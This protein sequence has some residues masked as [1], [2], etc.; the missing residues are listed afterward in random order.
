MS[1]SDEQVRAALFVVQ[2][3]LAKLNAVQPLPADFLGD[4]LADLDAIGA[5]ISVTNLLATIRIARKV[6]ELLRAVRLPSLKT[7]GDVAAPLPPAMRRQPSPA[8]GAGAARPAAVEGKTLLQCAEDLLAKLLFLLVAKGAAVDQ[9]VIDQGFLPLLLNCLLEEGTPSGK[10]FAA[11]ALLCCLERDGLRDFV[12][13]LPGLSGIVRFLGDDGDDGM[14]PLFVDVVALLRSLAD[15]PEFPERFAIDEV[16]VGLV[17]AVRVVPTYE[18]VV[19]NVFSFLQLFSGQKGFMHRLFSEFGEPLIIVLA[20]QVLGMSR[21]SSDALICV[22]D[23]LSSVLERFEWLASLGSKIVEPVDISLCVEFLSVN[24]DPQVLKSVLHLIA[25]FCGDLNCVARFCCFREFVSLFSKPVVIDNPPVCAQLLNVIERFTFYNQNYCPNKLV[26]A[27]PRLLKS[28]DVLLLGSTLRI[29]RQ[30]TA[31]G[32][33]FLMSDLVPQLVVAQVANDDPTVSWL[34]LRTVQ[35]FL[36]LFG[37]VAAAAW[38]DAGG[39]AR[40]F[41][42]LEKETLCSAQ[43]MA[44]AGLIPMLSGFTPEEKV[45]LVQLIKQFEGYQTI[46]KLNAV[47]T[48][49]T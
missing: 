35:Q 25:V 36:S 17:N 10:L 28:S 22:A 46:E 47:I 24:S 3:E 38:E 27:F 30:I 19:L 37:G 9:V 13:R 23:W 33:E 31:P 5:E 7:A 12:A 11:H 16:A 14:V 4:L 42:L 8:V 32:R 6:L 40:L 15:S 1:Q 18:T 21:S 41:A 26:W 20:L 34:A 43:L 45:A 48:R 39:K 29:I 49:L 2:R 44:L